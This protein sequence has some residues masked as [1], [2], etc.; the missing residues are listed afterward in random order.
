MHSRDRHGAAHH[1][2]ARLA[3]RLRSILY[4]ISISS[5]PITQ[6][7]QFLD[8][9]DG[10][11]R[12]DNPDDLGSMI[13]SMTRMETLMNRFAESCTTPS[14]PANGMM[15]SAHRSVADMDTMKATLDEMRDNLADFDDEVQPIRNYR[16]YWS[17]T[18]STSRLVRVCGRPS[19]PWTVSTDSTATCRH[20]QKDMSAMVDGM[21]D[22][23]AGMAD[24]SYT[25]V[26]QMVAE[27][28]ADHRHRDDHAAHSGHHPQQLRRH[29]AQMRQMTDTAT[30][31]GRG[32][33]RVKSDDHFYLPP[34]FDNPGFER[35][36]SSLSPDGKAAPSSSPTASTRRPRPD[37]DGRRGS[38]CGTWKRSRGVAGQRQITLTG[39][40]ATY[41]DI[42]DR[43]QSTTR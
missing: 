34:V 39:T 30:Y 18:V 19:R 28:P 36:D 37:L 16:F 29:D 32:V 20:W 2:A 25:T 21:G 11:H 5:V 4:Q 26:P 27:F 10:R 23:V 40:A 35:S 9:S 43:R 8:R 33:R 22:M 6:N 31:H 3:D 15:D 17:R 42:K 13:S 7:L 1:P 38:A 41:R 12:D 14:A 24:I